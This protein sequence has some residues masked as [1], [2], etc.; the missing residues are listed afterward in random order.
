MW[1][2]GLLEYDCLQGIDW[3]WSS[4]DGCMTKAPLG[5]KKNREKPDG[6][7]QGRRQAKSAGRW[8]RHTVGTG[9]RRRQP[10]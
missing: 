7:S 10:Q 3:D 4:M 2:A 8:R 5:G 9:S 1:R 6:S